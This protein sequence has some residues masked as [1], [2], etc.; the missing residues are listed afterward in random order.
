MIQFTEKII[1]R[2]R[3]KFSVFY[4]C[5]YIQNTGLIVR[6]YAEFV[7]G[8]FL[9]RTPIGVIIISMVLLCAFIVRGGIEVLGRAAQLFV[10]VFYFSNLYL[11]HF[12]DS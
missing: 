1:G 5:F 3:E 4:S 12:T 11:N 8:S 6:G 2:I 10:P 9:V 7:V